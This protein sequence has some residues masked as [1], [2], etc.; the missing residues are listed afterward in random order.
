MFTA[1]IKNDQAMVTALTIILINMA[2]YLTSN[3]ILYF[4]KYDF[5]GPIWEESYTLF[6]TVGGGFQIIGMMVLYPLLRKFRMTNEKVFRLSIFMALA[7]YALILLICFLGFSSNLIMLLIPAILVFS[8]NG[9]LTILTTIFLSS[10]VDY[11]Q[12]KTGH[13]EESVIFS[14]QT[15]VVKAA[16]GVSVFLTGLGIKVIGLVTDSADGVIAQQTPQT[17]LGLRLAMTILPILGLFIALVFFN[18][19]FK[20]TDAYAQEM[21]EKVKANG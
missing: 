3:F 13:R 10:S 2:L 15:F 7:G 18:K 4:F 12:I 16:S 11:G 8:A 19:K 9:M 20:M 1:L 6:S 21:A 14:M 5:G 17:L